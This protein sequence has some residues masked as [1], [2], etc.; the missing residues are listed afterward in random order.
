MSRQRRAQLAGGTYY[1]AQVAGGHQQLFRSAQDHRHFE[2]LLRGI[3]QRNDTQLLAYCALPDSIH[4]ALCIQAPLSRLVQG[5]TSSYARYLHRQTHEVGHVFR[6]RYR[7]ILIE[8][9]VWLPELVRYLHHL[10]VQAHLVETPHTYPYSSAAAYQGVKRVRELA[11]RPVLS[12]LAGRGLTA[13]A[14]RRFLAQPPTPDQCDAFRTNGTDSRVL[15]SITSRQRAERRTRRMSLSQLVDRIAAW[16]GVPRTELESR[17]RR[18]AASLA[19]ALI[20]W[21]ATEL[22]IGTLSEVARLFARDVSTLSKAI[23]HHR[24]RQPQL[25]RIDALPPQSPLL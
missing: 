23:S 17:S 8:P 19:R 4:L 14:A 24:T 5:L 12:I 6:R 20:A 10:P 11:V 2:T 16:Q 21:H 9:A 15:G 25:F 3:A 22:R 7:S 1:V 18:R 13:E